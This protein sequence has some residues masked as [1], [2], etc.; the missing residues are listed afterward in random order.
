MHTNYNRQL[1]AA[2]RQFDNTAPDDDT[3]AERR[4][5]IR[6][7]LEREWLA[8]PE[9][10][11]DAAEEII[12]WGYDHMHRDLAAAMQGH[13]DDQ[14]K[15]DLAF[16]AALRGKVTALIGA[17][18]RMEADTREEREWQELNEGRDDR[19]AA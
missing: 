19:R 5:E 16:M 12:G 13:P 10:L 15:R 1:S 7:E 9:K 2:A 8:S 4:D 3:R 18:A 14:D 11:E 17:N 6:Q